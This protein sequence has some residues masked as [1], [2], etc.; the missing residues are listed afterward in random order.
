MWNSRPMRLNILIYIFISQLSSKCYCRLS[1]TYSV[2]IGESDIACSWNITFLGGKIQLNGEWKNLVE[3][4]GE[5]YRN[6][7]Y[8]GRTKK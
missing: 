1:P 3:N 4:P 8:F 2:I 6:S 5:M 7:R